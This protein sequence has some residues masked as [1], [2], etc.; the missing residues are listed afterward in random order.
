MPKKSSCFLCLFKTDYIYSFKRTQHKSNNDGT[1]ITSYIKGIIQHSQLQGF[2]QNRLGDVVSAVCYTIY[3]F[4]L[5][6]CRQTA[7]TT[8]PEPFSGIKVA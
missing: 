3:T 6:L 8:S 7:E 1:N 4:Y 2:S 5:F